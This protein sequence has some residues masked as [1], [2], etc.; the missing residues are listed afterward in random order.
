MEKSAR[1]AWDAVLVWL[2]ARHDEA[3]DCEAQALKCLD[4]GDLAGHS[5]KMHDKARLLAAMKE[6][7]RPLVAALPE[8]QS[9]A[10]Q[11]ALDRFSASAKFGLRIDS[12]FYL[13]AL[14]YRDDHKA[15]EPDNLAVFIEG[16][17]KDAAKERP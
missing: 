4:A 2:R 14:L 13:S 12:L 5:A 10:V 1:A 16:L 11:H 9:G 8:Q 6:D 15:G 7:A 3:M 17:E